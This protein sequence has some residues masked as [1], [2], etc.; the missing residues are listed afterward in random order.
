MQTD[1]GGWTVF[2]RRQDASQ[3]FY[4]GW[5]DYQ[6][7]FGDL[8]KNFWLGLDKIHRLTKSDHNSLRVELMDFKN[9]TAYANYGEFSIASVSENYTLNVSDFTG[10]K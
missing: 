7:G 2:Q 1:V 5:Q 9:D 4:L 10:K 3:D 8:K 6:N